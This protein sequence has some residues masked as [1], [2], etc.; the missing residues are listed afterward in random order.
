MLL[1]AF[2]ANRIIL[3][4]YLQTRENNL[5]KLKSPN[6]K[7]NMENGLKVNRKGTGNLTQRKGM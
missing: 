3:S 2:V 1:Q 6:K 5:P 4:R 7:I